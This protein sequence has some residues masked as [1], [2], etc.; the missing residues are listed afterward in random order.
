MA[1]LQRKFQ[2]RFDFYRLNKPDH[3]VLCF[4]DQV[5]DVGMNPAITWTGYWTPLRFLL[6]LKLSSLFD[7]DLAR[8]A[9]A[10]R[11]EPDASRG[12]PP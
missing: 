10:A 6:L 7:E 11:I 8:A 4:F 1:A 3:A 5:F 9:W 2:F 12:A